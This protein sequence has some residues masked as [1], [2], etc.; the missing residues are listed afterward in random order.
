MGLLKLRIRIL[1]R[2][3]RKWV[4]ATSYANVTK[5]VVGRLIKNQIICLYGV[6]SKIITDNGSNLKNNMVEA[7]CKDF[8]IAHHNSSPY[9]PKMKGANETANKSTMKI[10]QKMVLTYKD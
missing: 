9:T 6:P 1:K 2:S 5:K 8:K 7:L 4:E 10:T 3:F